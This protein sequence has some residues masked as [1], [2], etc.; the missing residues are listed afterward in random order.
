MAETQQM[1]KSKTPSKGTP[2]AKQRISSDHLIAPQTPQSA[3][4]AAI[5]LRRSH[6]L[7]AATP[8][9]HPVLSTCDTPQ[10]VT[11][12]TKNLKNP[13]SIL[14]TTISITPASPQ[15][16]ESRRKRKFQEKSVASAERKKDLTSGKCRRADNKV[17]QK[18]Y[19]KKV[20]YDSGEFSAGHDVYVKKR[21]DASSDDEDPEVEEC[22]VCFKPAGRRV[23]IECDDCLNGFH[24]KCLS[25]P[26]RAVPEGDWM[27]NYCVAKKNGEM[28]EFAEPPAG[29]KRA[30]TAREKLLSS[31]LWAA[32]IES[33][34][35]EV[36]GTYWFRAR[37]YIIPEET[38]VGRQP[39]NL[40][41]E[42]YR[43]NDFADVEMESIIRHCSVMSPKDFANAGS[44]GDDVFICEY[45]YDIQW[46][47]FRRI[48][49][50]DN[51]E[52]DG[53]RVD[54]DDDDDDNDWSSCDEFDSDSKEDVVYEHEKK[55]R[56]S[57]ASLL[58]PVA[59]NSRKGRIFGL[60]K[61]GA[62]KI[63]EHL[64]CHKQT[65]L[66]KAKSKLLLATLP[67]S[68]PCRDREMDEITTFIKGAICDE[69]CLGRCL[70]VHGVPGTGKTMSVLAVMRNLKSEV[71][72]GSIRPY[73]FVEINGLK[74]ASPENIY[75]V[76]YEGLT[77][78]RVGWKKALNFLNARFSNENKCGKDTRPC[79]LLIDEL[80]L[81]V[82]RNQAVLYN[83]L[84]W[85]TKPNSKLIVIGIANTMDLP[86]KLLPRI[87]SRMGI[88]RLCFGP[89]NYQQL[90]EIISS[91]LKGIDAFEK[92][93]I[94]FA[95]R[96]VAAVSGDARRALEIC[97]RAAEVA[98]YRAKKT[99]LSGSDASGKVV[100]GMADVEAAIKEMFQAPH[101]QVIRSSC[102]LS[103]IFLAA[104][105]YE[106]YKTGM[107]ETTFEKLAMAVS[108]FCANN[109]ETFPGYDMLLKVG[110]KLGECRLLLCEAGTRHKL[111]KLQLNYPNDDVT[112]ALKDSKDLPWLAKYI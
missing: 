28:V 64:R 91:R 46:H 42:L 14:P 68:L 47:N 18:V 83:I 55:T 66:E 30:R 9:S 112:F 10:S 39:H 17:K 50:I 92:V 53:E 85:P 107:G 49:E 82:T 63:P 109:G 101:I 4:P 19:Y 3:T 29:K 105:V 67:K 74:L 38:A 21:S 87:S 35:K 16:T 88:Q 22:R 73:C 96:K 99:A 45:E 1:K 61:I 70:Y 25:P 77:G 13:T 15:P 72:A 62:K 80:D 69:Q 78:H 26:L 111:Q 6:R 106:L 90:Q 44:E 89:Y 94:E 65:D 20:V 76:I 100:A 12:T 24:L 27:C 48:A 40:R 8:E 108:C 97:R 5:N 59:A 41:R 56:L 37:W 51:N 86:E 43:T 93:A 84:D 58:H 110:C 33:L 102:K 98:D 32:R 52:D 57:H 60:Q 11:R 23:M 2:R 54:D 104:M 103:K 79:I 7:S 71:D 95:S 75:S 31:D 36:D 34:W 81:L